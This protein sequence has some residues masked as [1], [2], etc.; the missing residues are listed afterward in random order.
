VLFKRLLRIFFYFFSALFLILVAVAAIFFYYG[1]NLPSEKILLSYSPPVTTKIYSSENELIEEYAVERRVIVPFQEIPLIVKKAFIIAE[2]RDFNEH[3]GISFYSLLRAIV[4]NTAKKSWNKKPAGGSTITQQIAKNLLVGNERSLA[5]KCREAI[6]AFRIESTISKDKILEIYL[7]QLYLGKGC[8]GIVEACNYYFGKKIEDIEPHEAACLAAIPSAPS[9][10]INSR[11]SAKIL[12]KRNSILYQM[13]DLGYISDAQLKTS[14]SKPI[15]IKFRKNKVSSPYFSDEIF[16]IFTQVVS[17]DV[18][19]RCGFSI[20]TT[21][22]KEI[23]Y[24]A[25]KALE[26]GLIDFTK[27]KPWAGTICNIANELKSAKTILS[28][29]NVHM[30]TIL[31]KITHCVVVGNRGSMLVCKD[32]DDQIIKI[33]KSK[34]FYTDAN[35][36]NGDVVLCRIMEDNSYELFQ[37]P[38][39]TGGIVVMDMGNGNILG[40][41]GGFSFDINFFNCITQARRQPGSTIKPFIYA[42][43]LENGFDEYAIID[44]SPV[45]ITLPSGEVYAPHNYT[46]KSYGKIFLRDALIHSRNLST[47]N[48]ALKLG[49][50]PINQVLNTVEIT[51]K[52]VPI[53]GVLGSVET[54]PLKLLSAFS[55]IFNEGVMLFPR[56]IINIKQTG[57]LKVL[58]ETTSKFLCG[59]RRKY[60]LSKKTA[61]IIKNI[62]HDVVKLGTA[63]RLLPLEQEFGINIFGKTGTTSDFKDAW[64]IGAFSTG[65]KMLLICIFVGYQIPKSLGKHASG[66]RIALPIFEHF[67]KLFFKR[68]EQR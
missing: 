29:L 49:M 34:A 10:Y 40:L 58:D 9:I 3:S 36:K 56:F 13:R 26:D 25:T 27:T 8:Y 18:F 57:P 67:V 44:D 30:P 17:R 20:T 55:A 47:V 48:L 43:A 1:R 35:L 15:N 66:S 63:A 28:N 14:V 24:C 52:N 16:K 37:M 6:M 45:K 41:S 38:E 62:M 11:N 65:S 59:E 5:R 7:N 12:I 51:D 2:D 61:E 53:S 68:N 22:N 21:M 50:K 31:N 33:M 23:Q 42:A 46:M 32:S 4:E 60:V 54:T 19:P 64:F 39:V